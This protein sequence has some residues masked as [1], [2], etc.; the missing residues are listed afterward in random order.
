[1]NK[2]SVLGVTKNVSSKGL[3]LDAPMYFDT[4]QQLA[5]LLDWH[6]G[7]ISEVGRVRWFAGQRFTNSGRPEFG[8]QLI[9]PNQGYL[10]MLEEVVYLSYVRERNGG[11]R[12]V[13][14]VRLTCCNTR[15]LIDQYDRNIHQGGMFVPTRHPLHE[16]AQVGLHLIMLDTMELLEL[17]GRVVSTVDAETAQRLDVQPGMQVRIESFPAQDSERLR[18]HVER[19]RQGDFDVTSQDETELAP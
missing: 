4:D 3:A 14:P 13:N 11:V 12:Y 7:A 9:E 5:L 2:P 19:L 8:L 1:M 10:K 15:Q 17:G 16:G 6:S 18:E